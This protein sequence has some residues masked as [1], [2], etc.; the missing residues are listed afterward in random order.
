MGYT[1]ISFSNCGYK[2]KGLLGFVPM[3]FFFFG[4][5][6]NARSI[7]TYQLNRCQYERIQGKP[8]GSF[9]IYRHWSSPMHCAAI[10][11]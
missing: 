3:V 11:F 5:T 1:F 2:I 4:A 10:L 6:I 8:S 9:N 7:G